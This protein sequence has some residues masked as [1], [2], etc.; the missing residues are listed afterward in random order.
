MIGL[1][2]SLFERVKEQAPNTFE[3][4]SDASCIFQSVLAWLSSLCSIKLVPMVVLFLSSNVHSSLD[5]FQWTWVFNWLISN[6]RL[7]ISLV[8][9][10]GILRLDL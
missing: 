9:V 1:K 5:L 4:A 2:S 3:D 7:A 8:L 10:D 6:C